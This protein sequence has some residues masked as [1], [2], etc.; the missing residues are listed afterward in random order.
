VVGH[1]IQHGAASGR[2]ETPGVGDP[3]SAGEDVLNAASTSGL[4]MAPAPQAAPRPADAAVSRSIRRHFV[5]SLAERRR[6]LLSMW[7]GV[8]ANPDDRAARARLSRHLRVLGEAAARA[9]ATSIESAARATDR[10]LPHAVDAGGAVLDPLVDATLDAMA[11]VSQQ[12]APVVAARLP[13]AVFDLPDPAQ[14][15][16]L[17]EILLAAGCQVQAAE[18]DPVLPRDAAGHVVLVAAACANAARLAA[19]REAAARSG[20]PLRLAVLGESPDADVRRGWLA[21]DGVLPEP[22]ERQALLAAVEGEIAALSDPVRCVALLGLDAAHAD[23]AVALSAAGFVVASIASDADVWELSRAHGVDAVLVAPSAGEV[24][25]VE[26]AALLAQR[27]H[28]SAIEVIRI[29]ADG[30]DAGRLFAC[31]VA[32]L[33]ADLPPSAAAGALRERLQRGRRAAPSDIDPVSGALRR[34][35]FLLLM[36]AML[37]GPAP[38]VGIGSIDLDGLRRINEEFG[39]R[40]GDEALRAVARRL[41]AA[42]PATAVLGRA[43]GDEFLFGFTARN[44]AES[45]RLMAQAASPPADGEAAMRLTNCIGGVLLD[46]DDRAQRLPM[47]ELIARAGEL[48]LDGKSGH[49]SRIALA[50][51]GERPIGERWF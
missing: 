45:R 11:A 13:M 3:M 37:D 9:G 27:P 35:P 40:A 44:E 6:L 39:R 43:G 17:E 5:A 14:L 22:G 46:R 31:G 25:A 33:P 16:W 34:A 50:R 49:G 48:M 24:R 19:W 1:S 15:A 2:T 47:A 51:Y 20:R 32:R 12:D 29:G 28:A 8:R 4:S 21:A 18:A 23:W 26:L 41:R 36:Q 10:N 30:D 42:L 7:Q 38:F